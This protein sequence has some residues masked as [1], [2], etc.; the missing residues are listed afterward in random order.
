MQDR[1]AVMRDLRERGV[2]KLPDGEEFV[3][4]IAAHGGG[5][6]LYNPQIWK[7]YGVPDYEVNAQGKLT[8]MGE[9]TRWRVEDLLDTG[10]TA[11]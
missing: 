3:A 11:D 7:R 8:R 1:R 5:Y 6:A 4:G 10:Q 9:S 2:Y